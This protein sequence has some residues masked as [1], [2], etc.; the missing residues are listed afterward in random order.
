MTLI[1]GGIVPGAFFIAVPIDH[2]LF[3]LSCSSPR[4]WYLVCRCFCFSRWGC[5]SWLMCRVSW[6]MHLRPSLSSRRPAA[7]SLSL[8]PQT[9]PP[10]HV[11]CSYF[12]APNSHAKEIRLGNAH[13]Q[14]PPATGVAAGLARPSPVRRRRR[15][16]RLLCR[17]QRIGRFGRGGGVG[18]FARQQE[19]VVRLLGFAAGVG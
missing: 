19:E 12:W 1:D 6:L 17:R 7:H 11:F 2:E 4:L 16:V 13:P 18:I 5:V 3:R 10:L 14:H 8:N 15:R 9:P